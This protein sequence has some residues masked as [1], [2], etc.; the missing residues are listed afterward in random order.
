MFNSITIGINPDLIDSFITVSWH[1]FFTFVATVVAVVLVAGIHVRVPILTLG[2]PSQWKRVTVLRVTG[3]ARREGISSDDVYS[4]TVW[5]IIGGIVGARFIHVID[6]WDIYGDNLGQILSVW[7]GGIAIYGAIIGGFIG[8][9][10]YI[11]INHRYFGKLKHIS[12]GRLADVT[13]PALLVAQAIGRLGDIINGEHLA[14]V[15]D[16][17]WGFIYSNTGSLANRHHGL[18]ASH[19]AVAYELIYDL[20]VLGVLLKLRGRLAP[21]GMLFALY[22]MLYALGRFF[23][24]FLRLDKEWFVGLQEAHVIS[25]IVMAITVGVLASRVR[26]VKREE[27]PQQQDAPRRPRPRSKAHS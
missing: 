2:R 6:R 20:V 10:S 7:Q 15:T 22:G 1:G 13:A 16:L 4:V 12:I 14:K 17:P 25:L 9:A 19:P 24:Q 8:G 11:W 3:W 21:P 26:W 23:L 18:I 27:I 5:A